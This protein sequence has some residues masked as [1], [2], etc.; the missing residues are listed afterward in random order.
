MWSIIYCI[1][2]KPSKSVLLYSV[3][4]GDNRVEYIDKHMRLIYNTYDEDS[5]QYWNNDDFT[6]APASKQLTSKFCEVYTIS[7][8]T[9]NNKY[10]K[11]FEKYDIH[12][13]EREY[14]DIWIIETG[15]EINMM[16]IVNDI[17]LLSADRKDM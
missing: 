17:K 1:K 9:I 5:S 12:I 16:D 13:T 14:I 10:L 2:N 15:Y 11:L 6:D 3:I 7:P 8:A 4:D